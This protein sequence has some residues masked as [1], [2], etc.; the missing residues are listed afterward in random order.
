MQ[1]TQVVATLLT[2]GG[3]I[4][5]F[6]KPLLGR[7]IDRFGE[8]TI[9]MGEAVI[10]VFVCLGYGFSKEILPEQYAVILAF[11]CFIIDQLLMSVGMAR[12]TYMKKIALRPED[13]S[14]TLTMGTSIDHIFSIGIALVS[15]VVWLTL[16]YQYVFL[17]GAVIALVNLYS[18]SRIDIGTPVSK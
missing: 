3:V 13:I 2:I 17:I 9:L 5:I 11:A 16:G 6:F 4:G 15:G 18:A 14:Q 10:L 12:A 1:K 8:R 7:W